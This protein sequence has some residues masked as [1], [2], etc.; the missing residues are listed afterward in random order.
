MIY[1]QLEKFSDYSDWGCAMEN[2]ERCFVTAE[3]IGDHFRA[4]GGSFATV[5]LA[6]RA[7]EE[8]CRNRHGGGGSFQ[9]FRSGRAS[10][11]AA[12]VVAGLPTGDPMGCRGVYRVVVANSMQ[13]SWRDGAFQFEQGPA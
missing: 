1:Q 7:A 12:I 8:H 2:G 9:V 10:D 3:L 6:I 5:D 4:I 11:T 13:G